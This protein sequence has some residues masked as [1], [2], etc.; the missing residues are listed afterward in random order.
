MNGTKRMIENTSGIIPIEYKV[1]VRIDKTSEKVG[2]IFI[3]DAVKDQKDMAEVKGTMIAHGG[4]AFGDFGDP[5]PKAGDRVM[6]AK[7]AG[8][9]VSG[10]DGLEY[11]IVSDKDI[12]S[13]ITNE[14]A[15]VSEF[16]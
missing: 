10:A 4:K 16:A 12:S 13:I 1:L 6:I 8:K 9:L 7:Y 15:K 14:A 2:S 3:P 5:F 11:R